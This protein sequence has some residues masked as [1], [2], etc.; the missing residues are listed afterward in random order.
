[1][2][3][4]LLCLGLVNDMV[5]PESEFA[6]KRGYAQFAEKHDT[7]KQIAHVQDQF[8]QL[9]Q[10]VVHFRFGFSKDYIE[11]PDDSPLY[12]SIPEMGALQLGTWGTDLHET[13][14]KVEGEPAMVKHRLSPF[15]RTRLELILSAR[16]ISHLYICGA[17]TNLSVA[18]AARSAHD[19]DYQVTVLSDCCI[20]GD[21]QL[22]EQAL[23][24]LKAIANVETFT[25]ASVKFALQTT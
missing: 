1:M 21:Q 22:H 16:K 19:R 10:L 2:R 8:R 9:G 3:S 18:S 13:V 20:A 25:E 6:Q 23:T 14:D 5:H 4:A 17:A 12:K 11:L 24:N 7:L 15:F